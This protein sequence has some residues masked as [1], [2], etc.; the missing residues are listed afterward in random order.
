[1]LVLLGR[2]HMENKLC[3]IR[4][5]QRMHCGVMILIPNARLGPKE[6]KICHTVR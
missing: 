2:E 6:F 5:Q 4:A 1:M 3:V